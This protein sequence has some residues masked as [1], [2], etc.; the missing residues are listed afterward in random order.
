MFIVFGIENDQNI[1]CLDRIN[2]NWKSVIF[3]TKE[4]TDSSDLY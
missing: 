4:I 2:V 1:P 3:W